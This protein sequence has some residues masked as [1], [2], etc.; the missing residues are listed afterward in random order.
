MHGR[1]ARRRRNVVGQLRLITT[2]LDDRRVP[3]NKWKETANDNFHYASMIE[4]SLDP[5]H[6]NEPYSLVR[7][8][9]VTTNQ[10]K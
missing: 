3:D 2:D 10:E 5:R 6:R 8:G 1:T 4:P 9:L 7:V